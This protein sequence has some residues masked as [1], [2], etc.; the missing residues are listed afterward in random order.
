MAG[1]SKFAKVSGDFV[2]VQEEQILKF[3]TEIMKRVNEEGSTLL[4]A[5]SSYCEEFDVDYD[6]V[7][8]LISVPL[9]EKLKFEVYSS[10]LAKG[11]VSNSLFGV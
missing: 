7:K 11:E 5:I 6:S 3:Q 8:N 4:E 1:K 2:V 9:M 10:R